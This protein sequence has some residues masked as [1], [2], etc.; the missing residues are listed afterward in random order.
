MPRP[1][2]GGEQDNIDAD[3]VARPGIARHQH[4][5]RRGDAGEAAFVDREV[6]LGGGGAGLHLDEGYQ[7][8]LSG[9]QVDFARRSADTTVKYSPALE[10][11]PPCRKAFAT[12]TRCFGFASLPVTSGGYS[13]HRSVELSGVEIKGKLPRVPTPMEEHNPEIPIRIVNSK[14]RLSPY[15]LAQIPCYVG[16]VINGICHHLIVVERSER[17]GYRIH[18]EVRESHG[19]LLV[20]GRDI[21]L[22][23]IPILIGAIRERDIVRTSE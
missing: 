13:F 1:C 10:S 19:N 6:E 15:D 4:L 7:V 14:M 9:N 5:R 17:I 22:R 2:A 21:D 23:R 16:N 20:E 11:Q 8:P 12:P 3:V 18:A